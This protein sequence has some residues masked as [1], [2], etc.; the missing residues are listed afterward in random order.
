MIEN[1]DETHFNEY[2][3]D[4]FVVVSFSAPWCPDCRHIEPMLE[5]LDKEFQ[6]KL[7]IFKVSFDTQ[8][9]LKNALN[10]RKIPTLIFYKNGVEVL[11][12]LIEPK[13][14]DDIRFMC[15]SLYNS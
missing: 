2:I 12:R 1:I 9:Q 10:I 8:I 11:E 13:S 4:G 15:N 5:I 14:I 6:S 7:R 3:K